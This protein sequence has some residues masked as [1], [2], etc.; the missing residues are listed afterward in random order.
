MGW[1]SKFVFVL[2]VYFAGFATAIYCL[3]PAPVEKKGVS[4]RK[5]VFGPSLRSDKIALSVNSGIRK[6]IA[7]GKEA[8]ARAAALIKEKVEEAQL[9]SENKVATFTS[10]GDCTRPRR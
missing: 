1:R 10:P 5:G 7:L 6:C 8:A 4:Q 9:Q 3:A 2:I